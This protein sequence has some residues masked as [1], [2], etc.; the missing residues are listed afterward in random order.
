[1]V[2]QLA[3]FLKPAQDGLEAV[4]LCGGKAGWPHHR[5]CDRHRL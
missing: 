5:S 4:D 3:A 2:E 1:V